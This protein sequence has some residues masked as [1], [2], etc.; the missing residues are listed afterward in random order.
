MLAAVSAR[1]DAPRGPSDNSNLW[2]VPPPPLR[3]YP[4]SPCR[5]RMFSPDLREGMVGA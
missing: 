2:G 5:T 1:L 3:P 4:G